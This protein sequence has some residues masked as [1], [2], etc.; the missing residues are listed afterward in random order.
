MD[1]VKY[2]FEDYVAM[3]AIAVGVVMF[4]LVLLQ[5][6]SMDTQLYVKCDG[7]CEIEAGRTIEPTIT[8]D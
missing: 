5:G 3:G 8:N 7:A 6:C 4:I 2:S 1:Q